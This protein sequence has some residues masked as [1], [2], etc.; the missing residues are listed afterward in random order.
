MEGYTNA[1]DYWSLGVTIYVLLFGALPF[2][3]EKV[4]GFV[5]YIEQHSVDNKKAVGPPDY[6]RWFDKVNRSVAN[7]QMS[8]DC[9]GILTGLLCIDEGK[10][11]G[12]GNNGVK[13]LKTHPWFKNISW[14][15]L[16]QKLMKP[17]FVQGSTTDGS[18]FLE[19][20]ESV[21]SDVTATYSSFSDMMA[22]NG[23]EE[24]KYQVSLGP[25]NECFQTYFRTWYVLFDL[26][27]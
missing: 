7:M 21:H 16:A 25:P 9:K 4:A 12:A 27:Y 24:I 5:R 11:L 19:T 10:R 2:H 3:H 22:D 6:A 17:P 20:G 26:S 18:L 14:N 1:V 8:D 23:S 15:L 13:N